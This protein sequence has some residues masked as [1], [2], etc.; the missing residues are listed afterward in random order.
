MAKNL[1][2]Q[3]VFAPGAANSGTIR[4]PGR[5]SLEQLLLI[6]NTSKN[7]IIYNFADAAFSGTTAVFTSGDDAT[8]FPKISQRQDGYTIITLA[9]NTTGQ[10][11]GDKLQIL[12]EES[13]NGVRIRPWAFGT[14][15]IERMRV[16]NPRSMIDADFEY[17][18]QPTKWAGYGVMRG[19]PSVY[20]FPGV[21]LTVSTIT[22]DFNATST[23]NSLITVTT[24]A[25][26]GLSAGQAVNITG[27]AP[28]TFGFSRADG[29]FI[30]FD[31][32]TTSQL[33]YFANGIVGTAN[34]QSLLTDTTLLKRGNL[35][36]GAAL[37]TT[38]AS[39]N[40]GN[41]TT[42]TVNFSSNHGLVPN[43]P[44][45][46]SMAGGTNPLNATGQFVVATVPSLTTITFVARS[47][48]VV[49]PGTPTLYALT[50]SSVTHRPFDGGVILTCKTPTFGAS[51]VRVSKKYFRYQS[52]K[53]LLWSTGTMFKPSYDIQTLTAGGTTIGSTVTCKV[54]D[55]DHGL[56]IGA[57]VTISG[58]ITSGYNGTYTVNGIT[59]DYTF[60]FLATSVLGAT[61]AVLDIQAKVGL[62]AW[63]GAIVRSG[64][65]DDQNGMFWEFDG[66]R[67][68]IVRRNATQQLTGTVSINSNSNA[69]TG[70]STRFTQQVRAGDKVVIR[71]MTHYVT[72]V[73][74][75]TSMS[76][77]PDFR[78]VTNLVGV[79]ANL[80]QE[81]RVTQSQF[82]IDKLDGTGPSGFVFDAG[83][84]Q[85]IGI[86]YTWY[87]AGFIDYMVRGS[88]G[89]WV[90]AHRIKNNN[91]NTEAHM[92]TGN[93]PVRYSVDNDG[94]PAT[95]YLTADPGSGGT[96]VTVNDNTYFPTAGTLYIDNE[97]ISYSGKSGTTQFTGCGRA[98][99]LTQWVQGSNYSGTA[100]AAAAHSVGTGVILVSNTATPTLSHWGSAL[101]CDGGFDEDR[102]YIF[103]YQ[104]TALAISTTTVSA[105]LIRLAPS[106]SNS[107]VGDLGSK[108]L[109]NRS[110]LLLDSV[111]IQ[112]Y[113][114]GPGASQGSV[115]I[116]GV[117]NPKNFSTAT[118]SSLNLESQGGQPS[119]A[120]VAQTVTW[121]TGTFAI[122]GEQ[123]FAFATTPNSDGRLD[124]TALKELTNSPF[125][126]VGAYP[127]GPDILAINVKTAVGT[128]AASVLLRW[129]EAQ[130]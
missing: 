47:G 101:I 77:T 32:P 1:V 130:A 10:L 58:A 104:R 59:D 86:Q 30:I 76:V 112:T 117:L 94:S 34:G 2:R 33:R 23:S 25:V 118:W 12:F 21:D 106:V 81:T 42:I 109:L 89:N 75:D 92:R 113:G 105:F 111:G 91:V 107:A 55:I 85:M 8:N 22:T 93:L 16:S 70:T 88:D 29:N 39:G 119:L 7:Q 43:C 56:Q 80:V 31:T 19:Y 68:N 61:T 9:A 74:S 73:A 96:T 78:G 83:K 54:D 44:I 69:I 27:L 60:T 126:G 71:G 84:M 120:Q 40:G 127:N 50:N 125:G 52:G 100:G 35:Y 45:Y 4:V 99:T 5:I 66:Q 14:D 53:G 108:E 51:V 13:E 46:C 57:S 49:T 72:Q 79:K 28:S 98:A 110:Q 20:E 129:G 3:Y 41:P 103:N 17:G 38:T 116:E 90:F 11:A 62:N 97:L 121:S 95:T 36:T 114:N 48:L 128:S 65:F 123:V 67:L 26:H 37:A 18:L 122:P 63:H 15:S 102:G 124:L 115:I 6:T 82:N 64:C 24:T 87:G